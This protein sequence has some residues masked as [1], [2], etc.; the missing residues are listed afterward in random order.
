MLYKCLFNV[1]CQSNSFWNWFRC[2]LYC[3]IQSLKGLTVVSKFV[4]FFFR[5]FFIYV[6]FNIN[7]YLDLFRDFL[8][9]D[10]VLF[11]YSDGNVIKN[12]FQYVKHLSNAEFMYEPFCHTTTPKIANNN[13]KDWLRVEN[14]SQILY[15]FLSV[16]QKLSFFQY[17]TPPTPHQQNQNEYTNSIAQM[18]THFA[19]LSLSLSL[20]VFYLCC[21]NVQITFHKLFATRTRGIKMRPQFF[22]YWWQ[23]DLNKIAF[24]CQCC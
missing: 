6:Y 19:P 3:R 18:L 23:Q 1:H 4:L 11:F 16:N 22:L 12:L 8:S 2:R 21:L 10:L 13:N 24:N 15:P 5:Y 9:I 7:E 20:S 17:L 14:L